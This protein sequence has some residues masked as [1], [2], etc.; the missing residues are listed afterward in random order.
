MSAVRF[1][2]VL[3]IVCESISTGVESNTQITKLANLRSLSQP[4][5]KK[6]K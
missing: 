4:T 1:G 3:D 6:K 2:S 5:G